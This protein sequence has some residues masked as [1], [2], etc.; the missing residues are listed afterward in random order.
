MNK[1]MGEKIMEVLVNLLPSRLQSAEPKTQRSASVE[2]AEAFE[3]EEEELDRLYGKDGYRSQTD[4]YTVDD[5]TERVAKIQ[6]TGSP[7]DD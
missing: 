2:R 7:I 5:L 3:K 1:K 4:G 6:E